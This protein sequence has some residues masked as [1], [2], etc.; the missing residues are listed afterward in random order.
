MEAFF[1]WSFGLFHELESVRNGT[2][3]LDFI[4]IFDLDLESEPWKI[5]FL[6]RISAYTES[7]HNVSSES[8]CH[9]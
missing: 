7:M 2:N 1:H 4:S 9:I 5:K 8:Y 6:Q 3:D